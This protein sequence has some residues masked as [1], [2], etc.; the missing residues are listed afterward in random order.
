MRTV[1]FP[2]LHINI[3]CVTLSKLPL[4]PVGFLICKVAIVMGSMMGASQVV[5]VMK[6]LSASAADVR[7]TGLIPESGRSPGV[8]SGN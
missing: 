4:F 8:G 1:L 2:H 6:N 7:Y 3:N 5:L